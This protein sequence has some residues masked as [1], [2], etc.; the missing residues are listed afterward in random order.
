MKKAPLILA[1]IICVAACKRTIHDSGCISILPSPATP[2]TVNAN[3]LDTIRSLF[4]ANNLS[5]AGMHFTTY[6]N[7]TY[8]A[9]GITT[10]YQSVFASPF[11][12]GLP[13]LV[14]PFYYWTFK[15]GILNP[16]ST[17]N[18]QYDYPGPDSTGHQT[19]EALRSIFIKTFQAAV[20]SRDNVVAVTRMNL[21]GIQLHDSCLEAVLGYIDAIYAPASTVKE[22]GKKLVKVWQVTVGSPGQ[23]VRGIPTVVYI[24]DSSGAA[25]SQF[26]TQWGVAIPID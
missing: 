18:S 13:L 15:D 6:N 11:I 20:T 25:R 21:N 2:K 14:P 16:S 24:V 1:L 4:A 8:M 23:P 19:P 22:S 12:N 5:T 17:H 10:H 26:P 3:Q 9:S 7:Q